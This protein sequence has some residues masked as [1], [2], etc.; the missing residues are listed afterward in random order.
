MQRKQPKRG[1]VSLEGSIE[2]CTHR[3]ACNAS[4]K[5]AGQSSF[6]APFSFAHDEPIMIVNVVAGLLPC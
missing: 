4:H 3:P 6:G 1:L 2:Q 5:R